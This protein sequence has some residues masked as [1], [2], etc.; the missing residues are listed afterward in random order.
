MRWRRRR[1]GLLLLDRPS[2]TEPLL[3]RL[4]RAGFREAGFVERLRALGVT[5]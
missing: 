4:R 2:E 5:Y 1:R 3:A